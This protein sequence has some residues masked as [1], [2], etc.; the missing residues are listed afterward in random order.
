MGEPEGGGARVGIDVG[1]TFTDVVAIGEGAR[2]WDVLKVPS[3]PV[4]PSVGVRD[5]LERLLTTHD[6][7]EIAFLGHGTTAATNA[8]LVKSGARTALLTTAG[9]TDVLEFR[10]MDRSGPLDPYDLQFRPPDPLVP[11]RRRFGVVERVDASGAM[12]EELTDAEVARAVERLVGCGAEAVAVSLLWAFVNPEHELRLR[13]AVREALPDVFVCC[14]HEVDPAVMEYERTSTTVV[15]A[16]LGPLMDRYLGKFGR[17][18]SELGLGAPRIMQSNGGLSSI[19]VARRTP[20]AL[21]ESGPAGG[22]AACTH[23]AREAGLGD[24][25]ATDMGGTSF[26]VA[27]IIDGRPHQHV[28]TQ[29]DGHAI[30]RPMLDI[31]SIGAGGG[32]IAWVDDAGA[33]RVGPASAGADPGPA[34]YGRG[35]ERPTVSDANAHLGYLDVLAGGGLEL[36]LDRA[37]KALHEHVSVPLGIGVDEAAAGVVRLVNAHMAD[38]MRVIAGERGMRP[39]D[40]TLMAYGGAGPVHAAALAR[41]LGIGRTVIPPHPGTL[42][43][44]GVAIGDLVH[45]FSR[46]VLRPL[47]SLDP[48]E[49]SG[50]LEALAEEARTVLAREGCPPD[51][52]RLEPYVVAR[53]LG[54]MHDLEV[55]LPELDE[56][57]VEAV[58]R[59]FHERHQQAYGFAV[60]EEPV[61]VTTARL[62]AVGVVDKPAFGLDDARVAPEPVDETRAWFEGGHLACPVYDRGPWDPEVSRK[63]P[64]IIREY[65]STTIV[66]PGQ[67]WHVDRLDSLVIV[68][69][70]A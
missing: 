44:L 64:A 54:Q 65:D 10:R 40:L 52:H 2:R 56:V 28:E 1:G 66:L 59:R 41:E 48:E 60:P 63:G 42:S 70:G 17:E 13:D 45:D 12:I 3:T 11:A 68:E 9:F 55:P 29:I 35:G 25:F 51:H 32:S 33:L 7:D 20:V 47:G 8:F 36:D 50:H 62:R 61:F 6:P 34:C 46:S 15:N 37:R 19:E 67:T 69:E 53:Y 27:L 39:G 21:L 58:G 4:D 31:R 49:L 16:Y 26:D 5:G 14:S 30:R 18:A 22:V 43:A 57:G 38:T 23:I 24:V